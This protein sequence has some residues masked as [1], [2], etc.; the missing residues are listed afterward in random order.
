[1]SQDALDIREGLTAQ[2][3]RGPGRPEPDQVCTTEGTPPATLT[4]QLTIMRAEEDH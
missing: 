4:D 1:M 3:L 2:V